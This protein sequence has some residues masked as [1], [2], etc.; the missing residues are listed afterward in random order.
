MSL[1]GPK[2]SC[3]RRRSLFTAATARVSLMPENSHSVTHAHYPT[4]YDLRIHAQEGSVLRKV[5][6]Q[7]A[8]Y[9]DVGHSA[10]VTRV[11]VD[12]L[13]AHGPF[14]EAKRRAAPLHAAA[15]PR[16]L[17]PRRQA[18]VQLHVGAK[19]RSACRGTPA[20][21]ERA[22]TVFA[23][24]MWMVRVEPSP[25]STPDPVLPNWASG[26]RCAGR[27]DRIVLEERG[28]GVSGGGG[29]GGTAARHC[30]P[31]PLP[32]TAARVAGVGSAPMQPAAGIPPSDPRHRSASP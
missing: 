9:V 3:S 27:R 22:R 10:A 1:C 13:A 16:E 24:T 18:A 30:C 12:A 7:Q 11:D 21:V 29:G 26:G 14:D 20:A 15:D 5:L 8:R 31:C 2:T 4:T 17:A 6:G 32:V 28:F 23:L 25:A 19:N